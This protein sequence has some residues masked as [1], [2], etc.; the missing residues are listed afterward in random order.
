M[1]TELP[2]IRMSARDV[3]Q[4]TTALNSKPSSQTHPVTLSQIQPGLPVSQVHCCAHAS[5]KNPLLQAVKQKQVTSLEEILSRAEVEIEW[6]ERLRMQEDPSTSTWKPISQEHEKLPF[7]FTHKSRTSHVFNT[8]LAHSS[9]SE[10][11]I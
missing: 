4:L 5:P 1:K 8:L 11:V 6:E 2:H 7:V 9:M 3:T 10:H